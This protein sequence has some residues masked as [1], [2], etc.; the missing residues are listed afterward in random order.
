MAD[1]TPITSV[2][3]CDLNKYY[4]MQDQF[5]ENNSGACPSPNHVVLN[6]LVTSSIKQYA[7]CSLHVRYKQKYVTQILYTPMSPRNPLPTF[8][9]LSVERYRL[10]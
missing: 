7:L 2:G 6:H 4:A 5:N 10:I 9:T 1:T 8:K 3:E